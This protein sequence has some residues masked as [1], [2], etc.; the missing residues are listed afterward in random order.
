MPSPLR[1]VAWECGDCATT[2]RGRE[3]L[4]CSYCRA[5]NPRRYEILAG[6][7]PAATARTVQ[8]MRTEQH[9]IVRA[10]SEARVVVVPR[11][12]VDH[13][14]LAERLRG[15][16]I[17][18]VGTK[19]SENGRIR[20]GAQRN[21]T[22]NYLCAKPKNT[23]KLEYSLSQICCFLLL[24]PRIRRYVLYLLT[25]LNKYIRTTRFHFFMARTKSDGT[26]MRRNKYLHHHAT[27]LSLLSFVSS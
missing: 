14:L 7:A 26:I 18:I 15:T 12:V 1:Q 25:I 11:P 10:A 27:P 3:Q 13:A 8:V 20:L 19:S 22:K 23:R 6:S 2:N 17:D 16:L 4:P 9:D 24:M 21:H 5:E